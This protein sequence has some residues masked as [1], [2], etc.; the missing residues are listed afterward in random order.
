MSDRDARFM[1][2]FWSE[3]FN[4]LGSHLNISSSYHPQTDGQTERFNSMLEEYLRHFVN[5][6]QKNWPQLLDVAQFYFN[7]QKSSSTNKSPFEI[8]TG[9]QPLLP[10]IVDEYSIKNPRAFNFTKEWK[11][12]TE[13]ARAYLEKA[14]KRMKK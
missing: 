3:L 7:A 9:Q 4:F 14:S 5:A 8:V 6:N 13:I 12:N 11:K 10:H 2:S 1:G